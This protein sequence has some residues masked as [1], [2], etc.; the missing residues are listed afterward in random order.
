MITCL[1]GLAAVV[2]MI[3]VGYLLVL[4]SP[5][6]YGKKTLETAVRVMLILT[7]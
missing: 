5:N 3:I 6:F 4:T 2:L 1:I 7:G